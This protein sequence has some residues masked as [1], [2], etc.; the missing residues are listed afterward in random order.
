MI[1]WNRILIRPVKKRY[2]A[3]PWVEYLAIPARPSDY[4]QHLF[5]WPEDIN[6]HLRL[7]GESEDRGKLSKKETQTW[8]LPVPIISSDAAIF[9]LFS[10]GKQALPIRAQAGWSSMDLMGRSSICKLFRLH[11]TAGTV[12][13]NRKNCNLI[14]WMN[15]LC[16]QAV[17]IRDLQMS[18]AEGPDINCWQHSKPQ[19][20]L[21]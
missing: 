10:L 12:L 15:V 18:E 16:F 4:R 17:G 2:L 14:N 13:P 19:I 5:Q 1:I 7:T 11:Q 9:K 20:K 6:N 3:L 21:H 8:D